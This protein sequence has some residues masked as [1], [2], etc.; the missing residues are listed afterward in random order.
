M[1]LVLIRHGDPDYSSCKYGGINHQGFGLV[2]LS[3]AGIEQARQVANNPLLEGAQLVISSPYTRAMQT[4][5]EIVRTTGLPLAV[6]PDLH[7]LMSDRTGAP[8]SKAEQ[9]A[10]HKDFLACHGS[11][12]EGEERAW[13]T[14]EQL[15]ARVTGAL[16]RYIHY[17][18]VVVV[19]HG[20]VIR[21]FVKEPD[22]GY[23]V[24]YVVQMEGGIHCHGWVDVPSKKK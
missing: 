2:P 3:E 17:D 16:N 10:L 14:V 5:A 21:R 18:K 8:H 23:C 1:E 12:P 19:T 24:P 15:S 9:D 22:I 13:E 4:A 7:E 6:E 11:W 20:G